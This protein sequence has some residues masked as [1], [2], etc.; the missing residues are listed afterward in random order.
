MKGQTNTY[1]NNLEIIHW[2]FDFGDASQIMFQL[3]LPNVK[4]FVLLGLNIS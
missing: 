3:E 4:H 2:A 1:L